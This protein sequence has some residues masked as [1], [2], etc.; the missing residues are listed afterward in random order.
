MRRCVAEARATGLLVVLVVVLG[1]VNLAVPAGATGATADGTAAAQEAPAD[2]GTRE[3]PAD[4]GGEEP[5]AAPAADPPLD[6]FG[7]HPVVPARLLDSRTANGGWTGKLFAGTNQDLSVTS[8][9]GVPSGAS[10]VVMNVTVTNGTAGS[11]L[12]A[13]PAGAPTPTAA[14]LNFAPGQTTSNQVLVQVGADGKVSVYNN[15]GDVHVIVDVLGWYSGV[16]V[17]EGG[18]GPAISGDG[19]HV[20][21]ESL[22]STLTEGDVNGVLDAFVRDLA[23]PLTE[24]VSVVD[25]TDG[26]TE[27]TGTRVDGHTGETVPQKN[28]TDVAITADGNIVVFTSNGDLAG[29]RPVDT[30]TGGVSTE[31]G[32]FTRTRS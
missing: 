7:F 18:L 2:E 13:F 6:G 1:M 32:V 12:T 26:G 10:A 17:A 24:R 16:Q 8:R 25:E 9:G 22:S 4:E 21:F 27:A 28:G 19:Q 30:E 29:N 20:A 15:S 23:A 31:P 3:A 11:Y 5:P 14:N